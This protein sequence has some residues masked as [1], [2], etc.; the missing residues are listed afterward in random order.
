MRG[1]EDVAGGGVEEGK[2]GFEAGEGVGMFGGLG[3]LEGR[4][5][6]GGEAVGV[7]DVP[8]AA[9]LAGLPCPA[10]SARGVAG[11]EVG[12]DGE[13]AEVKGLSVVEGL[14]RGDGGDGWEGSELRICG[15]VCAGLH[16]GG[17]P[18][19]G[20]DFGSA[21]MLELGDSSGVVVVDVGVE[22]ELDVFDAEAEGLDVG[23]YL[24]D[25]VG[26]CAVDED[27]AGVGR[28]ED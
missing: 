6:D 13:L 9:G 17:G 23:H 19:A 10:G 4:G 15:I 22:D 5:G 1:E 2:A 27:E 8:A 18:G 3:E 14:H 7:D 12:G 11:G 21:E 24:G 16:D 28:D 26:E 20:E 25:G